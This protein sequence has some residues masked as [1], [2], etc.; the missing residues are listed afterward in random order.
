LAAGGDGELTGSN[1]T[2]LRELWDA[3]TPTIGG[4]CRIPSGF[5]AE[6]VARSGYDW[7]CIDTQHGLAGQDTMV[8]ML[9]ALDACQVPS[10]VRVE[11][12]DPGLIMR[13]L[14]AGAQGVVV[15]LVNTAADARAAVQASSYPPRGFRSWGPARASLVHDGYSVEFANA[16]VVCMAMIETEEAVENIDEIMAVD[17][18]DGVYVGP[19]DLAVSCGRPPNG[20]GEFIEHLIKRVLDTCLQRGVVAGIH[21]ADA[22]AAI[23]RMREGFSMLAVANDAT[24]LALGSSAVVSAFRSADRGGEA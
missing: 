7:V 4:W 10:L 17:G 23:R 18:V 19:A 11:W 6:V 14:D 2:R 24:L 9:Q 16:S 15:P 22:G 13:A 8:S 20:D 3:R 5:S 1:V 12:N 21:C